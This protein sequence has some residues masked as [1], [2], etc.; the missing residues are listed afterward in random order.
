VYRIGQVKETTF[1]RFVVKNSIDAALMSIKERKQLE[2]DEIMDSAKLK[3]KLSVKELMSLFGEV[4]EDEEGRAF[5]FADEDENEHLR[6]M[7]EE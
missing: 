1:I 6:I 4:G 3:E 5:I 2:I 7:R